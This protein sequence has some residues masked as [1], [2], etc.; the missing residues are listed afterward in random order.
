MPP[1][2]TLIGAFIILAI[3]DIWLNGKNIQRKNRR[4]ILEKKLIYLYSPL[5]ANMKIGESILGKKS[6]IDT[7]A[8]R[9]EG[10]GELKKTI[11]DSILKYF[12]LA[13]KRL[14]PYL[15]KIY[16]VGF[17][18]MNEK[19]VDKLLEYLEEDY[20]KLRKEYYE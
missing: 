3:R 6:L 19:D 13:S 8:F 17:Y 20:R 18:N 5:Y 7:K 4:D 15:T 9:E 14:Q 1:I 11:D 10:D 16:G 2:I 12:F